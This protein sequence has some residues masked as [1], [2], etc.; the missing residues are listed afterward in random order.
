MSSCLLSRPLF[1][2]ITQIAQQF[3]LGLLDAQ[4]KQFSQLSE[5]CMVKSMKHKA[6]NIH[7]T[8]N[9]NCIWGLGVRLNGQNNISA[10][11]NCTSK[12]KNAAYFPAYSR[13]FASGKK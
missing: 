8:Q 6:R 4:S 7:A 5:K 1:A 11:D 2:L 3:E 9:S 10:L 12:K 13:R